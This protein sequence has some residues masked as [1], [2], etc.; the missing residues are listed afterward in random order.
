MSD[1]L[2]WILV[3]LLPTALGYGIVGGIRAARWAAERR[4]A[5]SY[6]SQP[7][8]EPIERLA[9]HACAA[10]APSWSRWRRASTCR[11]SSCACG[12]SAAPTSTR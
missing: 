9:A 5:A 7:T 12:R 4:S 6:Y 11:P 8:V 10:R 1:Y 3:I 2:E